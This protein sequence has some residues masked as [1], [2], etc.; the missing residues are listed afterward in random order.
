MP[1]RSMIRKKVW[2]MLCANFGRDGGGWFLLRS[3][4]GRGGT[5]SKIS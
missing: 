5:G 4:G 3:T 1:R 2:R